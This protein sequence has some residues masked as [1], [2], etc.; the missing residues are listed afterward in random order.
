MVLFDDVVEVFDLTELDARPAFGIVVFDRRRVGA[1]LVDRDLFRRAVPLDRLAQEPQRGFAIPFGGQQE[2]R[3]GPRL[4]D[5][6]IQILP[7][8]LART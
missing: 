7:G 1:A 5:G 4:V 2:I 8:A 6:P 3:R